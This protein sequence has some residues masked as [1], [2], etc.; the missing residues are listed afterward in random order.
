MAKGGYVS[1]PVVLSAAV[2]RIPIVI[3]ESDVHLG[4]SNLLVGRFAKR[5]C[6]SFA[7]TSGL[8]EWAK[9]RVR[10]T[11][12]PM[13]SAFLS[14]SASKGRD[15]MG[16]KDEKPVLL[17]TGGSSGSAGMNRAILTN[18]DALTSFCNVYL[19]CGNGKKSDFKKGGFV[20]CEF[21]D[22]IMDLMK[23]SSLCVTRAGAGGLANVCALGVPSVVIPL[24][25][26]ASDHQNKNAKALAE[27]GAFKICSESDMGKPEFV[28]LIKDLILDEKK[29]KDLSSCALEMSDTDGAIKVC[30]VIRDVV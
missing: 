14:A 26:A 4:L 15:L 21:S 18:L 23:A 7:N 5:I 17:V 3:H 28:D 2:L 20:E 29:L 24:D 22:D 8:P 10:V 12:N 16:F 13:K 19:L 30:N 1:V 6:L 25:S 27:F 9:D 11:G